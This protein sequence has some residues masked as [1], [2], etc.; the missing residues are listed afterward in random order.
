VALGLMHG[1]GEAYPFGTTKD[2]LAA[3]RKAHYAHGLYEHQLCYSPWTHAL[4]T[5][6]ASVAPCCSAPRVTL[7]DLQYQ[8]FADI[9]QGESYRQLRHAMRDGEPLPNCAGCD[10]FLAENRT[11]HRILLSHQD[12]KGAEND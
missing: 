10:V 8:S 5:A 6:D 12:A 7:G 2:E 11:L 9:W 3:S 1:Q 4:V